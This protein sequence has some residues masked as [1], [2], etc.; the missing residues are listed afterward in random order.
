MQIAP[1][2]VVKG[3][4]MSPRVDQLMTRGVNKLERVFD[5]I[6][7]T[8][9][10]LEREQGRHQTGYPYRMRIDI[11]VPGRPDVVVEHFANARKRVSDAESEAQVE[12]ELADDVEEAP[13]RPV[14]RGAEPKRPAKEERVY[15]LI[16]RTFDSAARELQKAVDKQR[17]EVKTPATNRLSG[18]V[19][20]L[21]REKGYGFIRSLEGEEV[22][23]HRNSVLHG[24]W[25]AM[26]PGS[27]VRYVEELGEKGLQASTVELTPPLA[28]GELH[29]QVHDLPHVAEL[30]P[31][32]V[33]R[34]GGRQ[35]RRSAGA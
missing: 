27:G 19:A 8:R 12:V 2:I 9:I 26:K 4:G 15:A 10:A 21:L 29:H 31:K 6:V 25:D 35:A 13:A 1:E 3:M 14:R 22:Y 28:A 5:N 16:R 20:S 17:A 23:F 32:K 30:R 34:R 24:Q 33:P 18:V 7:S 11:K